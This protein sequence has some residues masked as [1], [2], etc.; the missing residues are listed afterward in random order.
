MRHGR[1]FEIAVIFCVV[2]ILSLGCVRPTISIDGEVF[3][4]RG[5]HVTGAFVLLEHG[6]LQRDETVTD[7][8]GKYSFRVEAGYVDWFKRVQLTV[9]KAR[10][11]VWIKN[12]SS[13]EMKSHNQKVILR[14]L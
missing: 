13:E 4:E 11:R 2:I 5:E 12:L 1:I 6:N 10:Y 3:N 14:D 8:A 7:E 9:S